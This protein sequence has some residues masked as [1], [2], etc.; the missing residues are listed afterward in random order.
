MK[1]M[2]IKDMELV[3]GGVEEPVIKM[4]VKYEDEG[5][6]QYSFTV[7]NKKQTRPDPIIGMSATYEDGN[8]NT[9]I[10]VPIPSG[11]P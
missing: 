10:V 7:E 8:G 4:T 3:N 11:R 5:G 9:F 2:S 6:H 1:E